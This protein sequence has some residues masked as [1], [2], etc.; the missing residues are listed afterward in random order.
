MH[1]LLRRRCK[2]PLTIEEQHKKKIKHLRYMLLMMLLGW[3]LTLASGLVVW[4]A[5]GYPPVY[6]FE[7]NFGWGYKYVN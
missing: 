5:A 2:K 6:L 7:Q 3:T 4:R 1:S